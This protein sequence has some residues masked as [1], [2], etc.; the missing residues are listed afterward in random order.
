MKLIVGG[1]PS[2]DFIRTSKVLATRLRD[3]QKSQGIKGLVL[4]L[5]VNSVLLQQ[6]ISGHVL[7]DV[8]PL[9]PRVSR[10]KGGGL[11]RIIPSHHRL[12]IRN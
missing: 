9:G 8:T 6:A 5:K 7:V 10:T 1:K 12:I 11:P 3:I 2:L 4:Y